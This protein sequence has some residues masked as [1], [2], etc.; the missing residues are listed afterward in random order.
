MR[1]VIAN[2]LSISPRA[3]SAG[4]CAVL[5]DDQ[6]IAEG[7]GWGS[8]Y[9]KVMRRADR[10]QLAEPQAAIIELQLP[11]EIPDQE[12]PNNSSGH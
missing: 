12:A 10:Q 3:F 8:A 4:N 2:F 5:F 11:G 6:L 1:R 7:L 9:S